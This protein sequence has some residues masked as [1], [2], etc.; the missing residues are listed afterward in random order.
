MFACGFCGTAEPE[1]K[2][3]LLA[4]PVVPVASPVKVDYWKVM[5]SEVPLSAELRDAFV[6]VR[7]GF[8]LFLSLCV[9]YIT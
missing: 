3:R 5:P 6:A 8:P 2:A 7:A 4:G 9:A 1:E